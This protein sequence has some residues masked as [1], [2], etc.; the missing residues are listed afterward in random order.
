[1][2]FEEVFESA[3]QEILSLAF[4]YVGNNDAEVEDIWAYTNFENRSQATGIFYKINGQVVEQYAVNTA[5]KE[6]VDDDSDRQESLGSLVADEASKIAAAFEQE[7]RE[8]PCEMF[9]AYH[10]PTQKF[11]ADFGYQPKVPARDA[12]KTWEQPYNDYL[13]SKGGTPY[14]D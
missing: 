13:R 6:P 3:S 9:L 10:V 4:E 5:L 2:S 8:L 14:E 1:M 7:A 11:E 12:T